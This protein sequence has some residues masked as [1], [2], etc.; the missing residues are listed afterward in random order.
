MKQFSL[1][2]CWP[3]S[4]VP[5]D[6]TL[7]M[8]PSAEIIGAAMHDNCALSQHVSIDALVSPSTRDHHME[9]PNRITYSQHTLRPNQFDERVGDSGFGIALRIRGEV[10]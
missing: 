6:L 10:P 8:I 3:A 2:A 7:L 9:N 4:G 1:T 5:C